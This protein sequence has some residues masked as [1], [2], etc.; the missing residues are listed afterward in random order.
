MP[1]PAAQVEEEPEEHTQ[2]PAAPVTDATL[3]MLHSSCAHIR[4]N[5]LPHVLSRY[6]S[7]WHDR[8][9]L[10][11]P[12]TDLRVHPRMAS[13]PEILPVNPPD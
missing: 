1:Q 6:S 3:L 9:P 11:T 10:R 12:L 2:Q 4:T 13:S 5:L 8:P 7:L